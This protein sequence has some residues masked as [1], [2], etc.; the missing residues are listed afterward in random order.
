MVWQLSDVGVS[1]WMLC[2]IS[3]R[4]FCTVQHLLGHTAGHLASLPA[5]HKCQQCLSIIVTTNEISSISNCL[6]VGGAWY[7]AGLSTARG[8]WYRRWR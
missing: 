2:A 7:S 6:I 8:T 1:G 4:K 5:I 3:V